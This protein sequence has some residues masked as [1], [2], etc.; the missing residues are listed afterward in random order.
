MTSGIILFMTGVGIGGLAVILS[1]V[2]LFTKKSSKRRIDAK[3][4]EKY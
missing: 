3:M 2:L 1:L 4:K